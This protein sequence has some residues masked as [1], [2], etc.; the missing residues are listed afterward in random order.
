M[1][2]ESTPAAQ[3]KNRFFLRLFIAGEGA[4]SRIARENLKQLQIKYPAHEFSIEVVDL[5]QNPVLALEQGVFI[6]PALQVLEP[7]S[8]GIVYGN[9][10]DEHILEQVLN[11]F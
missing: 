4:N 5:N 1:V 8:G 7:P 3:K 11:L 9:L 6:S 10:S 2:T